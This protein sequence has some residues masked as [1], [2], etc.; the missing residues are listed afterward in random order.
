M[1][2]LIIVMVLLFLPVLAIA[3]TAPDFKDIDSDANG[4]LNEKEFTSAVSTIDFKSADQN[5]DGSVDQA[6]YAMV[7][8]II[9]SNHG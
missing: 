7:K 6:E 3:G 2:K 5:G 1:K 8:K 9:E 4:V